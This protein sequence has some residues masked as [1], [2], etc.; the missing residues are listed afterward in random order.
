MWNFS[1]RQQTVKLI[2]LKVHG[3]AYF[4]HVAWDSSSEHHLKAVLIITAPCLAD[5]STS[6]FL[7]GTSACSWLPAAFSGERSEQC[8]A[9]QM[10]LIG[11]SLASCIV[12]MPWGWAWW[13]A[14]A[15]TPQ[16]LGQPVKPNS[17][18]LGS[19]LQSSQ[20]LYL[21]GTVSCEHGCTC[22][23]P[24]PLEDCPGTILFSVN[25]PIFLHWCRGLT[26]ASN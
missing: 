16:L 26:S 20:Q 13:G 14:L 7:H 24:Q 10:Q 6:V 12:A 25:Q 5:T 1:S 8:P 17:Q 4:C 3:V 9:D 19:R 23:C 2:S 22:S 11:W 21:K 15:Q 18:V